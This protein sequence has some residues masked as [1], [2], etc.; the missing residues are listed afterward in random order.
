MFMDI[1]TLIGLISAVIIVV[2]A[3]LSGS[4][5]WDFV[6]GPGIAI[7]V[8]GT[9]AVTLIKFPLSSIVEAFRLAFRTTFLDQTLRPVPLILELRKLGGFV[10]KDGLLGLEDY[11]TDN[12]FL[13]KTINL[14]VDGHP[15][16]FVEMVMMQEIDQS[17]LRYDAAERLFRGIGDSAPALGMLGTLVGLVQMLNNME[18]PSAIGPAMAVALLTT[19]YGA[20]IAQLVS[21]PLADK[22]K[23]KSEEEHRNMTLILASF[24]GIMQGQNPRLLAD[25][26][27]SYVPME[28]REQLS[29]TRKEPSL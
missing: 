23:M 12:A 13:R 6:N 9:M 8:F 1:S 11:Q 17:M 5:I 24:Q 14:C 25:I 27:A 26:L 16:E 2:A 15:P 3:I 19:F 4:E 18:D 20:F 10:R 28:A 7:V 22:L 29:D 21:L